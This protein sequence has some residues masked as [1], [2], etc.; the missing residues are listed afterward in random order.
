MADTA[1]RLFADRGFERVTVAEVA[2]QA[3]VATATVFNYFPTKEDLFFFRL[4]AFGSQQVE[5]VRN[6]AV[7]E[8]VL[9]A[10]RRSLLES[11]GLLAQVEAGD[12]QALER[13]RTVN[14][15]IAASPA[16]QAREQ[17]ALARTADAL[18]AL[19]AAETGGPA[20]DVTAHAAANALVGVQRAL[21]DYTRRRLL[22]DQQSARLLTDVRGLARHA[23]A[24]LEQGLG[25]YAPGSAHPTRGPAAT[26][27]P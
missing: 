9:V 18:A 21:V 20:A 8:P 23:F 1:W 13:L 5:A 22:A 16:L 14:R 24:L 10:F 11:G 4:E 7:G 15:V 17:Q 12:P 2:R 6:R 25:D 19:L 27:S 26:H 3:E